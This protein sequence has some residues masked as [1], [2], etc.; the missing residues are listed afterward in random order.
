[1]VAH[2]TA[3]RNPDGWQFADCARAA[4]G[5]VTAALPSSIPKNFRRLTWLGM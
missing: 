5:H 2:C 1:M 3:P 4:G